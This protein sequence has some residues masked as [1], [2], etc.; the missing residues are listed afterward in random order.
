[1]HTH[2]NTAV[3]RLE[4]VTNIWQSAAYDHT[5]GVIEVRVLHFVF[6]ICGDDITAVNIPAVATIRCQSFYR[7]KIIITAVTTWC[8][9][10]LW[11]FFVLFHLSHVV[12]LIQ[13]Y[14]F[15][16]YKIRYRDFSL[17]SRKFE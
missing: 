15:K 5:H 7:R 6:D 2:E 17:V 8:R 14:A 4:T 16:I 10:S 12:P 9:G 13:I 3:N 1:M 11:I